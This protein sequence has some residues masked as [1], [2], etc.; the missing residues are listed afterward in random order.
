MR[1]WRLKLHD[2]TRRRV[3]SW[4]A[5]AVVCGGIACVPTEPSR[6]DGTL[7]SRDGKDSAVPACEEQIMTGMR[8]DARQAAC[9]LEKVRRK[10]E[11]WGLIT[12]SAPVEIV[13]EKE[14]LSLGPDSNFPSFREELTLAR[15]GTQ[16]T[17]AESR[18][19]VLSNGLTVEA[20]PPGTAF[21]PAVTNPTGGGT[22]TTSTT[23][24]ATSGA[25]PAVPNASTQATS[26]M[27]S[28]TFAPPGTLVTAPS[29][30]SERQAL[31]IAAGDKMHA[32][33][34]RA[35]TRDNGYRGYNRMVF[36]VV[37]VS[38]NP[39]WRTRNN[40]VGDCTAEIEYYDRMLNAPIPHCERRQPTVFSVLPLIDAQTIEAQNSERRFSEFA[41]DIAAAFP[42]QYANIKARDLL[43][44]A[45]RFQK[46]ARSRT[47][48]PVVNTY[49]TGR[50]MGFRF[51]PSFQALKDPAATSSGTANVLIPTT[52]PALVTIV[53]ND[54]DLKALRI[55]GTDGTRYGLIV[56]ISTRWY[57]NDRPPLIS[58]Y[59]RIGRPLARE[60]SMQRL[61]M[62]DD[63]AQMFSYYHKVEAAAAGP[64]HRFDPVCEELRRDVLELE[65][66]GIGQSWPIPLS[67]DILRATAGSYPSTTPEVGLITPA[68]VNVGDAVVFTLAGS[69]LDRVKSVTVGGVNAPIVDHAPGRLRIYAEKITRPSGADELA[70]ATSA[71]EKS[72]ATALAAITSAAEKLKGA[73]D[74][75]T[76]TF[77]TYESDA[78]P[79][80]KEIGRLGLEAY[81]LALA[82]TGALPKNMPTGDAIPKTDFPLDNLDRNW[83][84]C[85]S[86]IKQTVDAMTRAYAS[87]PPG[88]S[89]FENADQSARHTALTVSLARLWANSQLVIVAWQTAADKVKDLTAKKSSDD[90]AI[91]IVLT[92]ESGRTIQLVGILP[93]VRATSGAP[94]AEPKVVWAAPLTPPATTPSVATLGKRSEADARTLALWPGGSG[95][96]GIPPVAGLATPSTRAAHEWEDDLPSR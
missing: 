88:T 8:K 29:G 26:M 85:L 2:P 75:L 34:Q 1:N 31:N 9:Y 32:N 41:A 95:D 3:A 11:E 33:L 65:A 73:A 4:L 48:Q 96:R 49:S 94:N 21:V 83:V 82:A 22:T 54:A 53:L 93:K 80:K 17:V 6:A 90:N 14:Y 39:G 62:A 28:T 70:N 89:G 72:R 79:K 47:A 52:F 40:Y 76:A 27:S 5:G 37:Q 84:D 35:M 19:R 74:D 45:S 46:D 10:V 30:I 23:T 78:D 43:K 81:T 87:L 25:A 7:A 86:L 36:A 51:S 61:D 59:R 66:K 38:C 20:T 13:D 58:W 60:T 63:V 50:I 18:E 91:Q 44:I 92:L 15:T 57:L 69:G 67:R 55:L 77:K 56:H 42:T 24:T 16:A 12:I 71:R 64:V 68:E